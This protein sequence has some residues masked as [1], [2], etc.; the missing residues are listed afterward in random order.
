MIYYMDIRELEA[1]EEFTERLHTFVQRGT[2]REMS[3]KR[4]RRQLEHD[5]GIA[6]AEMLNL[7]YGKKSRWQYEEHGKPFFEEGICFNISHAADYV[8]CIADNLPCGID[9][10]KFTDRIPN[11]GHHVL[12]S[13]ETVFMEQIPEE[14]K[15][16]AHYKLWTGKEGYL[17]A[18][19]KGL[20]EAPN[21]FSLIDSDG[22]WKEKLGRYRIWPIN[23]GEGYACTAFVEAAIEEPVIQ[24][25]GK[26]ELET[27]LSSTHCC[28]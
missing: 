14:E 2:S 21:S 3:S 7:D 25:I 20:Y 5:T 27:F 13:Q 8:V 22:N 15:I 26:E 11:L 17:K 12:T 1:D 9:V 18:I 4:K 23:L 19:G 24:H 6:L 16:K 10:E 28:R